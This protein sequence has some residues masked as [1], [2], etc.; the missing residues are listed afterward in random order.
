[1]SPDDR[2]AR[3]ALEQIDRELTALLDAVR[4]DDR[5]LATEHATR[6]TEGLPPWA[7]QL[8]ER[9]MRFAA[10]ELEAITKSALSLFGG[11]KA[12]PDLRQTLAAAAAEIDAAVRCWAPRAAA[13]AAP[14]SRPPARTS[15]VRS[16]LTP[17]VVEGAKR[18]FEAAV[19]RRRAVEEARVKAAEAAEAARAEAE[20][21][22]ADKQR[23]AW[24]ED[25]RFRKDLLDVQIRRGTIL[26]GIL[27]D[28]AR[29][30]QELRS[31]PNYGR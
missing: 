5:L 27:K 1:M 14:P 19:E 21:E 26:T 28:T 8:A 23:K 7:R 2:Y 3:V 11:P 24:E 12:P 10:R 17:D 20:R 9:R 16:T 6:G 30:L 29:K 15:R 13:P 4:E 18:R 22:A 31:R 25:Y